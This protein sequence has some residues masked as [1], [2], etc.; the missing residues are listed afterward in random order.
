MITAWLGVN[1]PVE[2]ADLWAIA[3]LGNS[4]NARRLIPFLTE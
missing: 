2:E 3:R 4:Y 1:A